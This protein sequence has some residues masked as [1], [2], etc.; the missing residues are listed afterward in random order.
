MK[1]PAELNAF[2]KSYESRNKKNS[3]PLLDGIKHRGGYSFLTDGFSALCIKD[4]SESNETDPNIAQIIETRKNAKTF[5]TVKT[6]DLIQASKNCGVIAREASGAVY[7]AALENGEIYMTAESLGTGTATRKISGTYTGKP[8]VIAVNY[9]YAEVLAKFFTHLETVTIEIVAP[10]APLFIAHNDRVSLVMPMTVDNPRDVTE[11]AAFIS[12]NIEPTESGKSLILPAR[13]SE[14]YEMETIETARNWTM[15]QY[16]E[17]YKAEPIRVTMPEWIVSK[18]TENAREF[19]VDDITNEI[20]TDK[21]DEQQAQINFIVRTVAKNPESTKPEANPE[22]AAPVEVVY[23][24]RQPRSTKTIFAPKT[25]TP[26]ADP[27]AAIVAKYAWVTRWENDPE[28][29]KFKATIHNAKVNMREE[30]AALDNTPIDITA[31]LAAI[32]QRIRSKTP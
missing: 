7:L 19:I 6:A 16:Q 26:P 22:P 29:R 5:L 1:K 3:R 15:Y 12:R 30:L 24:H 4:D 13:G 11:Q 17:D 8:A 23:K 25:V 27:R 10:G 21:D 20:I 31:G 14:H 32:S 28:K 2:I 18:P 9:I